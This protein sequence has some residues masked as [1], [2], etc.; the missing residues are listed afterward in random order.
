MSKWLAFAMVGFTV[1]AVVGAIVVKLVLMRPNFLPCDN[2]EHVTD[3][4]KVVE[5]LQRYVVAHASG[6]PDIGT[7]RA[8]MKALDQ[9][10]GPSQYKQLSDCLEKAETGTEATKCVPTD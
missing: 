3:G 5:R 8:V 2:L 9:T 6:H 1:V 10:L 7:C 4:D